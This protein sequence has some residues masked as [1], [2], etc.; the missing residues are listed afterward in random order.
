MELKFIEPIPKTQWYINTKEGK[1]L[2]ENDYFY[3]YSDFIGKHI[4][5]IFSADEVL[6]N[7]QS[8]CKPIRETITDTIYNKIKELK[9]QP[10]SLLV[11]YEV[12]SKE[13]INGSV[14]FK[15]KITKC[16]ADCG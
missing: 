13:I 4:E 3:A 12:V 8:G 9:K 1:Q 10:N 16:E 14:L 15:V 6:V 5:L 2:I 11:R 7:M